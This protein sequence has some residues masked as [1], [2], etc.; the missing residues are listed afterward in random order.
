MRTFYRLTI[1]TIL[2]LFIVSLMTPSFSFASSLDSEIVTDQ[3]ADDQTKSDLS[4]PEVQVLDPKSSA[5]PYIDPG[6]DVRKG[7]EITPREPIISYIYTKTNVT[8]YK[9]WYPYRRVSEYI[10]LIQR[11]EI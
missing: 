1:I 4:K 8:T 9:N 6:K 3:T 11:V 2:L 10:P 5:L 7:S